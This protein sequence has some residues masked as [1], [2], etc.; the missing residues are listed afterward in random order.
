VADVDET[1]TRFG[2]AGTYLLNRNWTFSVT[3]DHDNVD[4]DDPARSMERDRIGFNAAL[5]F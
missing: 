5:S 4:S 3:Y 1:T 2:L